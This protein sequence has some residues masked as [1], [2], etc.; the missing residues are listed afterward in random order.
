VMIPR[1]G[2]VPS[3][4]ALA[5]VDPGG[6][7]PGAIDAMFYDGHV[8]QV[9]LENLWNLHWNMNWVVPAKRPGR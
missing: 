3:A 8:E 9:K 5:D 1:H 7:L 6:N 4:G 2:S